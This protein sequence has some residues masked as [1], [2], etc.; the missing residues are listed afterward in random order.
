[1]T[2]Q[3]GKQIII[4]HILPNITVNKSNQAMKFDRLIE[5]K[6]KNIFLK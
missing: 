1:M 3:T 5:Y 2:L 6:M 4:I